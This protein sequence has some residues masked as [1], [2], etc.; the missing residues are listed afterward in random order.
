LIT[1]KVDISAHANVSRDAL[2]AHETQ[3]DPNST[4]W[5]GIVP[6][7]EK[8][9]GYTDDYVIARSLVDSDESTGDLFSGVVDGV[10]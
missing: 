10:R 2:L 7:I 4:M 3:I 8:E 6:E 9:L 1:T 5:F